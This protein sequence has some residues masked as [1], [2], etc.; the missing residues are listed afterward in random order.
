M[1]KREIPK[2]E[3]TFGAL[4]FAMDK[5]HDKVIGMMDQEP[6]GKVLDVPTGTGIL[7]DRLRKMGFEMSCCD[8]NPSFFSV[9]DLKVDIG[10]LNQSLPYADDSFDYLICLEGIEHTEN[11]SNAIREFQRILKKGGKIFISTPNFLN[12]E[13]RI[14]F[15]FTGNFSKIPSHEAIRDI[16]KGDLCMAHLSPLGY[17]LLKFIMEWYGFRILRLEKDQP[18]RKIAWLLP[19]VWLIRL[20]GRMAS[21]KRREAYRL[22]ET[23]SDEIILGGNTLIIMAEKSQ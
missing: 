19:F 16:W 18:K 1:T 21:K 22:D 23:L 20:Y 14:R 6:R 17:S 4:P 5:T 12:I 8:I 15:F 2:I 9:P 3:W 13:R 10:D 7:A 11:P